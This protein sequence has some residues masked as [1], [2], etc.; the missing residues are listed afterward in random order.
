[1]SDALNKVNDKVKAVAALV[2][3]AIALDDDGASVLPETFVKDNLAVIT[4]SEEASMEGLKMYQ[5]GESNLAAGLVLGLS[6]VTLPAM[7]ANKDLARTTA[8]VEYGDNVIR[9]AIDRSQT[10]RIPQTGEEKLKF[11]ATSVKLDSGA[12]AKRGDLKRVLSH[13]GEAF[14]P[15]GE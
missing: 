5:V 2:E 10:I 14:A 13:I 11:G 4:G 9:A 1:M 6:N 7:K 15:L 3:G 12:S 8:S